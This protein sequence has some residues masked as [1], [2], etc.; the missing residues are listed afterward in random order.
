MRLAFRS[1]TWV[2][3]DICHATFETPDGASLEAVFHVERS[4]VGV[5][6]SPEPDVFRDCD[7]T[8]EEVRQVVATVVRFCLLAQGES[9][10]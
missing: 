4:P 5:L 1:L 3:T 10:D 2:A 8:A 7:G 9:L 6:A